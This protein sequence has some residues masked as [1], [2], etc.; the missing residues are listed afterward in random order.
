MLSIVHQ[1]FMLLNLNAVMS[2]IANVPGK[3]SRDTLRKPDSKQSI[4]Q[5]LSS[6]P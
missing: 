4:V 2:I 5:L 3:H 6:L 1:I